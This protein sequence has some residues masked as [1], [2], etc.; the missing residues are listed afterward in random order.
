MLFIVTDFIP[1]ASQIDFQPINKGLSRKT[2]R[3]FEE[4]I[5]SITKGGSIKDIQD[6]GTPMTTV[7]SKKAKDALNIVFSNK[8]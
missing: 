8:T 7:R 2:R 4:D 5:G 1:K 6:L 3:V